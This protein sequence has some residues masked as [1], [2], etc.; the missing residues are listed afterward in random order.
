MKLLILLLTS[1]KYDLLLRCIESIKKQDYKLDYDIKIVVNTKKDDYYKHVKEN[2]TDYEVIRTESNGHP[3]KGHNSL[4]T[5]FNERSE[6]DYMLPMDGD[7]ML[8]PCAFSQLSKFLIHQPDLVHTMINDHIVRENTEKKYQEL[9]FNYKLITT[10]NNDI[11][12]FQTSTFNKLG[13]PFEKKIYKCITPSRIILISR[14]LSTAKLITYAENLT[15]YDDYTSFMDIMNIQLNRKEYKVFLTSESNVYFYDKLNELS[16]TKNFQRENPELEDA[17]MR[18]H[19]KRYTFKW[20]DI[21]TVDYMGITPPESFL[22]EDKVNFCNELVEKDFL[23]YLRNAKTDYITGMKF[24]SELKYYD[25]IV[26]K[27]IITSDAPLNQKIKHGEMLI[28]L[29]PLEENYELMLQLMTKH[30]I[31]QKI[32]EYYNILR[33]MN[34]IKYNNTL[35]YKVNEEKKD[36]PILC[37]YVGESPEFNGKDYQEQ[38]V[39]GSEIAAVKLCEQLTNRYDVY[40]INNASAEITHNGVTYIHFN[41]F[42]RFLIN[43]TVDRLI[44]SRFTH[45]FLIFDLE[46]VKTIDFILHDTRC[47]EQFFGSQL[48]GLG[49]PLFM[50]NYHRLNKIICV[51][52][53]QKNNFL[54]MLQT[55]KIDTKL[56]EE[57]IIIIPNGIDKR[58]REVDYE[59]KD[60]FRFIY[61]SDPSRGLLKLCNILIKLKEIYPQ[62]TL[63]IYYSRITDREIQEVVSNNDFITFHGRLSNDKLLKELEKTTFWVYPNINSHETFCIAGLEAMYSGNILLTLDTTGIGELTRDT[64]FTF[65]KDDSD[66]EYIKVLDNLIKDENLRKLHQEKSKEKSKQYYWEN[67]AKKW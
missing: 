14:K 67:I 2:I 33:E 32:V 37:Y 64:G 35:R 51:S 63:D 43:H 62:I 52:E 8:Y 56:I 44:I 16:A 45:A 54:H 50:N 7:D 58:K 22:L 65:N 34:P 23:D 12:F 30:N 40:I 31:N 66:E 39:Y 26:L 5:V 9:N 3:G 19:L 27:N 41:N 1:S 55:F 21:R 20:D 61:H 49:I 10:F 13:N 36:K 28:N 38:H 59:K 47:H 18:E 17:R 48:T 15:L 60:M 46:K 42:N 6:Y 24:I 29:L 53:W 4:Y 25:E 57:K 11:N